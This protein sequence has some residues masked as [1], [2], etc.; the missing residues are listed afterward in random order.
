MEQHEMNSG[1][2]PDESSDPSSVL[3]LWSLLEHPRIFL[4][5]A[6]SKTQSEHFFSSFKVQVSALYSNMDWTKL[7]YTRTFVSLLMSL[8]FQILCRFRSTPA[9]LPIHL[10]LGTNRHNA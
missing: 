6:I 8:A 9:A 7:R 10:L 1:C 2:S 4:T 5:I 3:R